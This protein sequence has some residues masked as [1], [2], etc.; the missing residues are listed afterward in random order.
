M[1]RSSLFWTVGAALMSAAPAFAYG[2]EGG[3]PDPAASWDELW[4]HILTD[5]CVIGGVF[6]F[7]AIY[8]LF[9][10]RADNINQVG[11]GPRLTKGQM[12]AWAMIPAFVFMADDFFLAAKGWDLWNVYRRVPANALE[13]KVT[14]RMWGWEFQYENGADTDVLK[15][16]VG[17]PVV[18]R[19]TSEDVVHSFFLPKYR[20][21]EDLMPGRVTYLWFNPKEIGKTFV[22]CAEFCGTNHANMNT[23]VEVVSADEFTAWLESNKPQA[24]AQAAPVAPAAPANAGETAQGKKI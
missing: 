16:P 15:V 19:M 10:Y 11:Q 24:P 20:V 4:G 12:F 22:T 1:K 3:I 7:A 2:G 14:G 9:K 18:L 17:R 8:M 23:D 21:K 6:A 5:L 13:V